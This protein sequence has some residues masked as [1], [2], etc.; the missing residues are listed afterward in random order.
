MCIR[1][2]S[3]DELLRWRPN[4]VFIYPLY[5][6]PLTGLGR[7]RD[8]QSDPTWD[9][10]RLACYRAGRDHL[11]TAGYNQQSMRMF[12]RDT[13]AGSNQPNY[14]CQVDG[15]LGLGCGARSYTRSLHYSTEYAVGR[16]AVHSILASYLARNP[17]CFASAQYGYQLDEEDQW[18]RF[19]LMSL[20]HVSGLDALSLIHI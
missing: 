2:R 14:C 13:S 20:L 11:L 1:D 4:E 16:Q 10:H 6:R 3:I 19:T 8:I 15:M 7:K 9:A 18:R 5:V 17:A 12:S